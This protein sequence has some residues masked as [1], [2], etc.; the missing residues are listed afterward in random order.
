MLNLANESTK[1]YYKT[2]SKIHGFVIGIIISK[3]ALLLNIFITVPFFEIPNGRNYQSFFSNPLL[4]I[5]VSLNILTVYLY[6]RNEIKK[7]KLIQYDYKKVQFTTIGL[8]IINF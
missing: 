2:R 6:W 1:L 3:I 7:I 5:L 4:W 8:L